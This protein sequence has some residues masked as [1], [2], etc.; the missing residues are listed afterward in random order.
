MVE[1]VCERSVIEVQGLSFAY[2]G[3]LV[4][5]DVNLTIC[6][7]EFVSIVGPNG[8]GKTT[9]LKLFLGLLQPTAGTVRVLGG[10]P[11]AARR[12]VGYMPQHVNLDP[13]FPVRVRDVVLMGRLGARRFA[14]YRKADRIA[15]DQALEELG[16]RDLRRRPFSDLSG[17]QRQRVLIAVPWPAI[18]NSSCWTS[19]PPISTRRSRASFTNCCDG[20]TNV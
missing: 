19:R 13:H 4:I 1:H 16:I 12:R 18:R 3:A 8:G 6:E 14:A 2:N 10:S 17:G 5:E 9:L 7:R 15:A 20:S 11:E